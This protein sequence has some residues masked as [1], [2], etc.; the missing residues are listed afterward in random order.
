MKT[1][2][3]DIHAHYPRA[4]SNFPER[5]IELLPQA[6]IDRICL[7]SAG[8]IFGHA[9]NET[10]LAAA[11]KYPEQIIAFAFVQLG[12]DPPE[13]IDRFAAEGYRGFKITTPASA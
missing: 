11:Q 13:A 10:I 5:L 9:S 7:F 8:E 12:K 4:E 3:I 1:P 2:V 6:G